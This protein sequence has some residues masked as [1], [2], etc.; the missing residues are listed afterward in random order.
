MVVV[1]NLKYIL[2]DLGREISFR[3]YFSMMTFRKL[4]CPLLASG[5]CNRKTMETLG[6]YHT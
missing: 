1:D 5:K 4:A 2:F 6:S 3:L